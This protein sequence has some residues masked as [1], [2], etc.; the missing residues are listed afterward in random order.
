MKLQ[1]DFDVNAII[2]I[3]FL[4]EQNSTFYWVDAKPIYNW[5]GLHNTGKFT[6]EG[7][8]NAADC[9]SSKYD[10]DQLKNLEYN[11]YPV[12]KRVCNKSYVQVK[13]THGSYARKFETDYEALEW[14]GYLEAKSG[15]SFETIQIN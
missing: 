2:S 7:W 14:I 10:A 11:V 12:S 15:K 13:L 9:Y 6:K 1:I 4:P 3:E 8:E 5:F